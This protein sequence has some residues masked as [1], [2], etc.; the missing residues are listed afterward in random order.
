M[1]RL[2]EQQARER[3]EESMIEIRTIERRLTEAIQWNEQTARTRSEGA[4]LPA[5]E[6]QFVESV[7]LQTKAAIADCQRRK[8]SAEQRAAELREAY[9]LAR[10]ERKTVSTLRENALRQF[11]IEQSRR[12]QNQLDEI[13]LGKLIHARNSGQQTSDMAKTE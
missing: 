7:L 12:E 10:L 11:Q 13:F 8:Q 3:L 6:L 1:R 5:A 4:P 2:L 9:L